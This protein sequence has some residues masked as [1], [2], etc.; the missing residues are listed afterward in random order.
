MLSGKYMRNF[1][2]TLAPA[3]FNASIRVFNDGRYAYMFE[4]TLVFLPAWVNSFQID[5]NAKLNY[6]L[7]K[8]VRKLEE[9]GF[10]FVFYQGNGCYSAKLER[11]CLS[12][13]SSY[14]PSREMSIFSIKPQLGG[15]MSIAT[16]AFNDRFVYNLGMHDIDMD[17]ILNVIVDSKVSIIA[18]NALDVIRKDNH[19]IYKWHLKSLSS[20][21]CI[22]LR[23]SSE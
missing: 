16:S 6:K 8:Y 18:Q 7:S 21:P 20:S 14:F 10:K 23:F 12:G 13:E 22:L 19:K 5:I 4:G 3:C 17:G 1:F 9:E 11:N 15:L 2:K